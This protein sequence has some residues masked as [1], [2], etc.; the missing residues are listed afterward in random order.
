MQELLFLAHRIPYPPNKGDKIRSY[1]LLRF[2]AQRYVVH[3]A[4]FVDD[5]NDWQYVDAVKALCNGGEVCVRPLHPRMARVKS[6]SGLATG[7]AL[8]LPYYRD[9]GMRGWVDSLLTRR[10]VQHAVV[11]SS[12]MAQ[13]VEHH[14]IRRI[15]DLVDVDSDK[16]TQYAAK[17]RWPGSWIYGREGRRLFDYERKIAGSFDATFFV[18]PAEAA[19]FHRLAPE[20][21]ARVYS[22][23]NG[24]DTEYFS[25]DAI[26]QNPF[27]DSRSTIVFTGAMDYWP[28]V[29]AVT[30]FAREA[31]PVVQRAR[32]DARFCIVGSR[33]TSQVLELGRLQGVEVTGTVPDVRPYLA[34]AR[35]IVAPLRIARGVQNKVLEAMAMGRPTLVTPQALEGIDA[36]PGRELVLA[37]EDGAAFGEAALQLL[38]SDDVAMG[39]AA[40]D[41]VMRDYAWSA[42]LKVVG[43]ALDRKGAALPESDTAG[44]AAITSLGGMAQ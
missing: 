4:T 40:R 41:R 27:G 26:Y 14:A 20:S 12:P 17:A 5:E 35:M 44:S 32:P 2:L 31:F 39:R 15:A 33:P 9:A 8:T 18:S 11:F 7:E 36:E 23:G 6:L 22:F 25:P 10:P 21:A 24:V 3:L 30:W 13:Y 28:N 42:H 19:L 34:H 1:H 16:W 37:P 43:Q 38:G 29:D